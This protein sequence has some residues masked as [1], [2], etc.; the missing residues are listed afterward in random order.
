MRSATFPLTLVN[1]W[2]I[3]LASL[4]DRLEVGRMTLD[5]ATG[6]RILLPQPLVLNVIGYPLLVI[7]KTSVVILHIY[8]SIVKHNS[9]YLS[10]TTVN[11]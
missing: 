2:S 11:L 7:G 1:L 8:Q 6:V 3:F 5:H 10:P 4:G 9:E